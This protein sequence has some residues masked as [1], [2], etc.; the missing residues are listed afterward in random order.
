M[1]IN[2]LNTRGTGPLPGRFQY[3]GFS[4]DLD[5]APARSLGEIVAMSAEDMAKAS[6]AV[7][8]AYDELL[9]TAASL[10]DPGYRRLMTE[11]IAKPQVTFLEM[12][13]GDDDRRKV[14]DE[15]VKLG[16][17]NAEDETSLVGIYQEIDE[18]TTAD[19]RTQSWRP[20]ES[21]VHWPAGMVTLLLML[22]SIALLLR[23]RNL[24]ATA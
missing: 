2:D 18:A 12:Y 9:Q 3:N 22:A 15:M 8:G 14:Y 1:T 7:C 5:L 23:R 19:L 10:E 21:L 17:F 11:C 6:R 4:E 20:R 24:K 16:F 13:P